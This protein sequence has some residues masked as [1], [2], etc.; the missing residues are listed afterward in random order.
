MLAG[1]R[2]RAALCPSLAGGMRGFTPPPVEKPGRTDAAL[3]AKRSCT[4]AHPP[5]EPRSTASAAAGGFPPRRALLLPG[6]SKQPRAC[7]AA[8]AASA[9]LNTKA[10]SNQRGT[11]R[12]GIACRWAEPPHTPSQCCGPAEGWGEGRPAPGRRAGTRRA[13]SSARGARESTWESARSKRPNIAKRGNLP[14]RYK[15]L[16]SPHPLEGAILKPLSLCS[17]ESQPIP[18]NCGSGAHQPLAGT[19]AATTAPND[20]SHTNRRAALGTTVLCHTLPQDGLKNLFLQ[21]FMHLP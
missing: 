3:Q 4:P 21:D 13:G 15:S 20:E 12:R 16:L 8:A 14:I 17:A 9:F 6:V 18:M 2:Q 5:T 7:L 1:Q 11:R 10:Q 19:V